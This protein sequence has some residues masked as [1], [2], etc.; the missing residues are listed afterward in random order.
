MSSTQS[1]S[2]VIIERLQKLRDIS[3]PPSYNG[4]ILGGKVKYLSHFSRTILDDDNIIRATEVEVE[5]ASIPP[6]RVIYPSVLPNSVG[7]GQDHEDQCVLFSI[8]H[9]NQVHSKE[10]IGQGKLAQHKQLIGGSFIKVGKKRFCFHPSHPFDTDSL[11]NANSPSSIEKYCLETNEGMLTFSFES[12]FIKPDWFFQGESHIVAPKARISDFLSLRLNL[13][14]D[15]VSTLA[16]L[17]VTRV[18][19]ILEELKVYSPFSE[20]FSKKPSEMIRST[21]L[22]RKCM[23]FLECGERSAVLDRGLYDCQLPNLGPTCFTNDLKRSYRV[24][25]DIRLAAEDVTFSLQTHMNIAVADLDHSKFERLDPF[26]EP[27]W[28]HRHNVCLLAF[29]RDEYRCLEEEKSVYRKIAFKQDGYFSHETKTYPV[30]DKIFTVS[31]IKFVCLTKDVDNSWEKCNCDSP[32]AFEISS[33][34]MSDCYIISELRPAFISQAS[35][36]SQRLATLCLKQGDLSC[37]FTFPSNAPCHDVKFLNYQWRNPCISTEIIPAKGAL[38]F[39]YNKP[40]HFLC[41]NDSHVIVSR[42]DLADFFTLHLIPDRAAEVLRFDEMQLSLE[43]ITIFLEQHESEN[44][45]GKFH[46]KLTIITLVKNDEPEL[47]FDDSVRVNDRKILTFPRAVYNCTIPLM[48][49]TF[50][51]ND[52]IREFMIRAIVKL[53]L[54]DGDVVTMEACTPVEVPRFENMIRNTEP[55]PYASR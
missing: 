38:S 34:R 43:H 47:L 54:S 21:L 45:P 53:K 13:E 10:S 35:S 33:L 55:P 41:I 31:K 42:K 16:T 48:K 19:V 44:L 27:Q 5:L 12:I 37:P 39:T 51:S 15:S 11:N 7:L 1:L 9:P 18:T 17:S 23:K 36:S 46:R 40:D 32:D 20:D 49:P 8:V 4:A 3:K 26:L 29:R 28:S 2:F 14:H 30:G 6:T 50:F 24:R 22:D 25:I 52:L